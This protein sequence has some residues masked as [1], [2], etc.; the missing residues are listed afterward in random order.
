M[1]A[2]LPQRMVE[3]CMRK[4]DDHIADRLLASLR[5]GLDAGGEINFVR[6]A[7]LLVA[8]KFEFA[9]INLRVDDHHDPVGE[10]ER[11]WKVYEPQLEHFLLR[12]TDP[13]S[14]P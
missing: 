8:Q 10:L 7:A 11:L 14:I 2:E 5:A 6:S 9:E 4:P 1:N 13:N 3:G 12:V